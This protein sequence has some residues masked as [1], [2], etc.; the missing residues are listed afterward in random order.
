MN[1][2]QLRAL[3]AIFDG[4][5]FTA[6]ASIVGLSHSAISLQI[7][8]LEDDLQIS[9]FDRSSRPPT[10]TRAGLKAAKL[11]RET[12]Q[13]VDNIKDIKNN[14]GELGS[15][16]IGVVPTT[17]Q[18]ITPLILRQ[19]QKN[20]PKLQMK[21][22][23]GLSGEL[24]A[25]ILNR[26]L[27]IA[28]VTAP[29]SAI[30]ELGVTELV[31]EPLFIIANKSTIG[32]ESQLLREHPFISF[33]RKTWL[34]QQISARLQSRGYFVN[35]VMEI[36]S[37]DAIERMVVD[38]FGV[39][40]V[41]KGFLSAPFPESIYSIQFCN[42]QETRRLVFIHRKNNESDLPLQIIQDIIKAVAG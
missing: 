31:I 21:L 3:K 6:A 5:S 1:L 36:D 27:D 32:T 2:Q 28:I 15:I 4:G 8:N 42:P 18:D 25:Q 30:P 16:S 37:I 40:I 23:S 19:M 7:K 20:H 29:T 17:L 24:T 34:G 13:L 35:E 38:G 9:L 22:R 39:S 14:V 26:E 10:F 12:L 33:S 41:P 11:A